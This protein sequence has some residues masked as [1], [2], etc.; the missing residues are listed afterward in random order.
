MNKFLLV[1]MCISYT[2]FSNAQNQE[3]AVKFEREIVNTKDVYGGWYNFGT[4]IYNSLGNTNYYRNHLFPD[5]SVQVEYSSGYSSVWKHSMGQVFDPAADS[6]AIGGTIP[7]DNSDPYTVDSI[8]VWYRYFR[9]QNANPDTLRVQVYTQQQMNNYPDPWSNGQ[10][11][12]TTDYDYTSHL[13]VN[14]VQDLT[15]L[16]DDSDTSMTFQNGLDIELNQDVNPGEFM[17]VTVTYFPG[18][19]T[20]FGDTIDQYL[21]TP[22]TNPINAFIM[23]NFQDNNEQFETD[24]YNHS[25]LIPSSIRYNENTLNWNGNYYP[26]IAYFN[27]IDHNDI[28]FHVVGTVGIEKKNLSDFMIYPNPARDVLT[29]RFNDGI[30]PDAI[31]IS[32]I[33]GKDVTHFAPLNGNSIDISQLA[34]GNYFL[35]H[36]QG[37]QS[38]TKKFVVSR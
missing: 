16:L 15:I 10:S 7:I 30:S 12:A 37:D 31:H 27:F 35:T 26:G 5:S 9:H 3:S 18:N 38:T 20:N 25:L 4:M 23:Y 22:P 21:T 6:W 17:A 13:G 28:D 33:T 32:D 11:Y 36:V 1:A 24:Y 2:F 14:P 19:P 29:I 34:N 8:R